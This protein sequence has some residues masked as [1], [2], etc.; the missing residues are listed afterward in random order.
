F[1]IFTP[2]GE[3]NIDATWNWTHAVSFKVGYQMLYLAHIAN[4]TAVNDY[5]INDDGTIF[6]VKEDK[7]DRN[8]DAFVH[9]VM[10]TVQVNR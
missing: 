1:N 5:R 3:V 6:G 2:G 10:F 7:H 4:A 9:G 8:F